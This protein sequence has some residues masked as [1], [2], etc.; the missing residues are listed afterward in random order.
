VPIVES[1]FRPAWWLR[2]PHAQTLWPTFFR[3][4]VDLPGER[5]RL[6]LPDGD[7]LDLVWTGPE[8]GPVVLVLH[9]LEG[10]LES[11]YAAH[12][13][14]LLSRRGYRVGFVFFRG[15]SGEP[16]RLPRSYH[17]GD[18]GDLDHLA[19]VVL[20]ARGLNLHAAVGYSLGG[21]VLLKWLGERGDDA[22]LERAAAVSV[23]FVLADAARRLDEGFSRVYQRHLMGRLRASFRRKFARMPCPLDVRVEELE[24]FRAFDDAVTAPLH[25]FAGADDYYRQSSSRQY[26]PRIRRPTLILH[27]RDDPFM[28]PRSAPRADELP[29]CVRLELSGRGGHV[30]FVSGPWPWRAQY[31]AQ[32]RIGEW[33]DGAQESR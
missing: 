13:I 24:G 27:S 21:N 26:L 25:G 1:A 23:P 17:S 33:L 12:L 10:S 5:E 29:D 19:R 7:F 30:G 32:R 4:R 11:H 16:N 15:C 2:G 31:W 18:T 22:P 3:R 14:A 6:E 20:P 9:G 28:Y 8:A